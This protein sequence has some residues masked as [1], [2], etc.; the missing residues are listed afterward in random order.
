MLAHYSGADALYRRLAGNGLVILMLHR[1]RD[2]HD[3]YPLSISRASL[4]RLVAWLRQA[5]LLT[6][7]D[8][9]LAALPATGKPRTRYAITLDDGYRDNLNLL[10][11]ALGKVPAVLYLATD[12]VGGEPIWIYR[13]LRAVQERGTDRADLR[14]IGMG[15]YDL[16]REDERSRLLADVPVHLKRLPHEEFCAQVEKIMETLAPAATGGRH[17]REMLDW[18]EVRRLH[19]HGISIGAHTC[20]HV[21]LSRVDDGFALREIAGSR[22]R[23]ASELGVPPRHFA[24]PN[25][26]P[27]DF[28]D[29]DV[30]MVAACGFATSA[31]TVE[32]VNRTD[33]PHHR[34]LR[35]N[36]HES[37][38][39]SPFGRISRAM[40]FSETSGL[41]GWMRNR[42]NRNA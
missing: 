33:T 21:L 23:I 35:Y 11:P 34:L 9:G 30:R 29:R 17:E 6:D 3:P 41:L 4:F 31:T 2:E 1:I 40:F 12:H 19:A 10:D 42:R 18:D 32:G 37:R 38:Y 5:D 20:R 15:E 14:A 26:S 36:V 8:Q 27:Q 7:L 28:G 13:L 24:Y 39:R 22:D 16:S 25:G